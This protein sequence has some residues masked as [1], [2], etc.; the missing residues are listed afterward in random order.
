RITSTENDPGTTSARSQVLLEVQ[1]FDIEV[2]SAL[3]EL[4]SD[5]T[6][7]ANGDTD[8]ADPAL[9]EA[10]TPADLRDPVGPPPATL[11]AW[12][13]WTT[14]GGVLGFIVLMVAI[15]WLAARAGQ[16]E[17]EPAVRHRTADEI[18][19]TSLNELDRAKL[20][21][22]ADGPA[23]HVDRAANI[24]RQYVEDRYGLR[25]P[26]LTTEEFLDEAR[27]SSVFE[28][29]DVVLFEQFLQKSDL[30]KFA[31]VSAS[32]SEATD[33]SQL[34][35]TFVERTRFNASGRATVIAFDADNQRIGRL[36]PGEIGG[37]WHTQEGEDSVLSHAPSFHHGGGTT[38][39]N[40]HQPATPEGA[41]ADPGGTES[42]EA[43]ATAGPSSSEEQR[44]RREGDDH[45]SL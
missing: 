5:A 20:V 11:P 4:D 10:M 37:R 25:A 13:W 45:V 36:A 24:L 17:P 39:L 6:Q 28:P 8:S 1:P 9:V 31:A 21:D 38:P 14:I 26:E 3:A 7:A 18:A 30:V 35:R 44:V 34:V 41:S 27:R 33:A 29:G 32:R 22:A 43:T 16:R 19:F 15:V 23:M 2:R 40:E 42:T 12:M